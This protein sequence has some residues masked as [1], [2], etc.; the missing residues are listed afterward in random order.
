MMPLREQALHSGNEVRDKSVCMFVC[1]TQN[2][3]LGLAYFSTLLANA[4]F[5]QR[6]SFVVSS[7]VE[8]SSIVTSVRADDWEPE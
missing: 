5:N 7:I 3:T 6:I 1:K 4:A 8:L 2:R